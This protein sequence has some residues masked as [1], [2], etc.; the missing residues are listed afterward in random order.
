MIFVL[1]IYKFIYT[2]S[3][4]LYNFI[5]LYNVYILM[6]TIDITL[7]YYK[8]WK[9]LLKIKRVNNTIQYLLA[10]SDIGS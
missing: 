4:F 7:L 10:D 6:G 8:N 3:F 2:H 5:F 9:H 1:I